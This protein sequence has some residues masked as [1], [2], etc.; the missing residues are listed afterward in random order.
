MTFL[1]VL[2]I[3]EGDYDYIHAKFFVPYPKSTPKKKLINN[4]PLRKCFDCD[5][6]I[7]GLCDALEQANIIEDD[8]LFSSMFVE[9]YRTTETVGRIEFELQTFED[10]PINAK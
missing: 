8:R 10:N 3:P 2:K 9:K 6:V 4:F 7:K 5:N 1:S